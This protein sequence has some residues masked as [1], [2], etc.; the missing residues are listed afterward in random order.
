MRV[1][2][3]IV[4]MLALQAL[5]IPAQAF[6]EGSS[7]LPNR[8]K[9]R[10]LNVRGLENHGADIQAMEETAA[11][12]IIE[13]FATT[14]DKLPKI[15][16]QQKHKESGVVRGGEES[17]KTKSRKSKHPYHHVAPKASSTK[18]PGGR[19]PTAPVMPPPP[20]T[21][22]YPVVKPPTKKDEG[23]DDSK[24]SS[25]KQGSQEKGDM[26]ATRAPKGVKGEKGYADTTKKAKTSDDKD[27][28][29]KGMKD[30]KNKGG[31]TKVPQFPGDDDIYDHVDG[32]EGSGGTDD[33]SAGVDTNSTAT[34]APRV[35]PTMAP[36]EPKDGRNDGDD[37]QNAAE[38]DGDNDD[39]WDDE[40]YNDDGDTDDGN[41]PVLPD[42]R[43]DG[44][45]DDMSRLV[46]IAVP[47]GSAAAIMMCCLAVFCCYRRKRVR[48][49]QD[50]HEIDAKIQSAE[51]GTHDGTADLTDARTFTFSDSG[52][53]KH[54]RM[55]G[56]AQPSDRSSTVEDELRGAM[57]S[58]EDFE[59]VSLHD[60][61]GNHARRSPPSGAKTT[62]TDHLFGSAFR[63]PGSPPM[64]Q[65]PTIE[66][67]AIT[68]AVS[69]DDSSTS[70]IYMTNQGTYEES[71]NEYES[72]SDSSAGDKEMFEEEVVED[73]VRNE[74]EHLTNDGFDEN[75]TGAPATGDH[76]KPTIIVQTEA[77]QTQSKNYAGNEKEHNDQDREANVIDLSTY[78]QETTLRSAVSTKSMSQA[79]TEN[80]EDKKEDPPTDCASIVSSET[81]PKN[82]QEAEQNVQVSDKT[83]SSSAS[84]SE[85]TSKAA[86]DNRPAWMKK[87]EERMAVASSKPAINEAATEKNE[88]DTQPALAKKVDEKKPETTSMPPSDTAAQVKEDTRPAWMKTTL[89]SA[90]PSPPSSPKKEEEDNV[91][92]WMRKYKQ[93]KFQKADN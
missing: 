53:E 34:R 5:L 30:G 58:L 88:E 74:G 85:N 66:A 12:E 60:D 84:P 55:L 72:S 44:D 49:P 41:I 47:V 6:P 26:G 87:A 7:G 23:S 51:E 67:P 90:S 93:M 78:D 37:V 52:I 24:K 82:H 15:P 89:R 19:L 56:M 36:T 3:E 79:V 1:A 69:R 83:I 28:Y 39:Y 11:H 29:P 40:F 43:G 50:I 80:I 59:E 14:K 16:G 45:D 42:Y 54:R 91:P 35:Q 21:K 73:E 75:M 8:R 65:V 20:S 2:K 31:K 10:L 61:D 27:K 57:E 4:Y 86:E 76:H 33:G 48:S 25:Y 63:P 38:R 13:T 32:D 92:E 70:D 81:Q 68:E 18:A 64:R 71:E 62:L 46:D 22:K 9:N 77:P 17:Y